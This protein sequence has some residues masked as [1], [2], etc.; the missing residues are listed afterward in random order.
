MRRSLSSQHLG[1]ISYL[2][3]VSNTIWPPW[4]VNNKTLPQPEYCVALQKHSQTKFRIPL[5]ECQEANLIIHLSSARMPWPIS[6]CCCQRC[7]QMTCFNNG[8]IC[9]TLKLDPLNR[10]CQLRVLCKKLLVV[11]F[12]RRKWDRPFFDF[13]QRAIETFQVDWCGRFLG[14]PR[15]NDG[16]NGCT[17]W[18]KKGHLR[19]KGCWSLT[20]KGNNA[21]KHVIQQQTC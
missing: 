11:D 10:F 13:S 4:I 15:K 20:I 16:L 7:L 18:D 19:L 2:C 1:F 3:C 12:I 8:N 9:R 6:A 17:G 14:S 5:I 21:G